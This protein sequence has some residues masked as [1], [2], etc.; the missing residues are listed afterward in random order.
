MSILIFT[1]L[2]GIKID[3][4]RNVRFTEKY[5]WWSSVVS[6]LI[7]CIFL[8]LLTAL[9]DS[10]SS[11]QL[12]QLLPEFYIFYWLSATSTVCF[13]MASLFKWVTNLQ[14]NLMIR[15]RL[16]KNLHYQVKSLLA[17]VHANH[18]CISHPCH[19]HN[20]FNHHGHHLRCHHH[21]HLQ[22]HHQILCLL[23]GLR[24]NPPQ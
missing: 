11:W 18:P 6:V 13:E 12:K 19:L 9:T 7:S 20:D 5:G 23:A 10:S 16:D 3:V 24:A 14:V 15:P 22:D 2:S 17:G 21:H 1:Y 8:K 4:A